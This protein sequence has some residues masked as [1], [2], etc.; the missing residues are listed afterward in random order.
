MKYIPQEF[1]VLLGVAVIVFA[2]LWGFSLLHLV[3]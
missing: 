1:W 3:H 2:F